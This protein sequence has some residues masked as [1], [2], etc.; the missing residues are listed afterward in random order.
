MA[1]V[2]LAYFEDMTTEQKR[3]FALTVRNVVALEVHGLKESEVLPDSVSVLVVPVAAESIS[4]ASVE[5]QVLVSGN[6]WPRGRQN[7]P[8]NAAEAKAHFDNLAA[9]IHETLCQL[10][11][12]KVFVW[13]TPFTASGW[14][15]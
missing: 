10:Y 12:V 6:D 11:P 1:Q 4:G 14:A 5:V 13:V 7:R 8:A 9:R 3:Q 2:N 15:S